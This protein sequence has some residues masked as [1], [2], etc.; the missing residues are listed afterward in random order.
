MD[1]KKRYIKL[2]KPVGL[3]ESFN[4][5][6]FGGLVRIAK[7]DC[8]PQKKPKQFLF[9]ALY[10]YHK[11]DTYTIFPIKDVVEYLTEDDMLKVITRARFYLDCPAALDIDYTKYYIGRHKRNSDI[12]IKKREGEKNNGT[13]RKQES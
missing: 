8:W 11:D 1:S 12:L 7:R 6:F 5:V 9:A 10:F 13:I 4:E 2:K 3:V